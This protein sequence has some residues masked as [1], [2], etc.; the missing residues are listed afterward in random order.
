MF[1]RP[2]MDTL[3]WITLKDDFLLWIIKKIYDTFVKLSYIFKIGEVSPVTSYSS[4][5]F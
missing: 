5:S 1:A 3:S 4:P 2:I